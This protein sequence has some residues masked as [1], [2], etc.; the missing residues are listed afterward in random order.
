MDEIC[1]VIPTTN[2]DRAHRKFENKGYFWGH[3][4]ENNTNQ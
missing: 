1:F 2:F 4:S 3:F